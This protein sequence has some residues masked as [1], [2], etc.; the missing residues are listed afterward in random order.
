M[1]LFQESMNIHF[2]HTAIRVSLIVLSL[3]SHTAVAEMQLTDVD[4]QQINA[5]FNRWND[6]FNHVSDAKPQTLYADEVEWY[7]QS[8]SAQ[9]VIDSEAVF[10]NKNKGY[11]QSI[12]SEPTIQAAYDN[13]AEVASD[14]VRVTFVKEVSPPSGKEQNYPAEFLVRKLPQGWRIVS[15]TD[16]VTRFNQKMK[17]GEEGDASVAKG[18][19][20]GRHESYVWT[21]SFDPRTGGICTEESDCNSLL[22]NSDPEIAP[23]YVTDRLIEG[24]IAL[25]ALDNS[26][27]DRVVVHTGWWMG[28]WSPLYLYD[29]QQKQWIRDIPPV[30]YNVNFEEDLTD[31]VIIKPDAARPGWVKIVNGD[32]DAV[33]NNSDEVTKTTSER[34]LVLQ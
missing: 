11:H 23:V 17:S 34:L 13:P 8:L 33:A 21:T 2:A 9:Q 24:V 1:R 29:I 27:R 31:D 10:V 26:G 20:D 25:P 5:L 4:E 3:A 15:E 14:D 18:K 28:G 7:G 12:V 22:W 16:G 32:M 6:V 30:S 19:F